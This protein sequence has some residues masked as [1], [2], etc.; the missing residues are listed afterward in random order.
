MH[1][2]IFFPYFKILDLN[3]SIYAYFLQRDSKIFVHNL[4][5]S[6]MHISP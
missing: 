4:L 3:I 5:E 1:F 2:L 6:K